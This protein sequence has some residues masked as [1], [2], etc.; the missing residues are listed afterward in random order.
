MGATG[1]GKSTFARALAAAIGAP[2]VHLDGLYSTPGWVAAASGS[3]SWR[4]ACAH[5]ELALQVVGG[6][7]LVRAVVASVAL[8]GRGPATNRKR[9]PACGSPQRGA[10][11]PQI[12]GEIRPASPA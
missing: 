6:A 4:E 7:A 5:G 1:A 11:L 9:S 3:W 8:S 12:V 2:V 10:D